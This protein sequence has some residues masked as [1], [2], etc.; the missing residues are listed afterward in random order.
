MRN[1]TDAFYLSRSVIRL[2]NATGED[3]KQVVMIVLHVKIA[4]LM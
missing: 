4:A 2:N 1:K 3:K